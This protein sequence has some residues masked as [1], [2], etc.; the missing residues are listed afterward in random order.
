MSHYDEQRN[1]LEIREYASRN[2]IGKPK[3]SYIS[4]K[5]LAPCA[6]VLEFGAAKYSRN[7]WKKGMPVSQILD[8]LLRHIGDLQEGKII[9]EESELAIIGHIQCNA[10]F[11]GNVNNHDDLTNDGSLYK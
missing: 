2:N 10:M 7:N 4:M 1:R 11:L 6:K 5:C 9:D 3:M 8:S